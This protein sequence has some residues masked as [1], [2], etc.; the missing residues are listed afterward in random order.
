M[1][2]KDEMEITLGGCKYRLRYAFT[3]YE[4]FSLDGG[5]EIM[6]NGSEEELSMEECDDLCKVFFLE[7]EEEAFIRHCME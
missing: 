4:E 1:E 6:P 2:Y 5:E 7:L 3:P